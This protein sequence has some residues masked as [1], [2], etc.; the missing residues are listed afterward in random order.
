M[1]GPAAF[2]WAEW[3]IALGWRELLT[4]ERALQSRT[5]LEL[6]REM[7]YD[8]RTGAPDRKRPFGLGDW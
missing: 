2:A 7:T 4:A 1:T 5:L 8:A 6:D 3:L